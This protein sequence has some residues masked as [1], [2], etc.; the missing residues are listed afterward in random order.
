[1]DPDW[2]HFSMESRSRKG[3]FHE[4]HV[5]RRNGVIVCSCEDAVYRKKRGYV[6]DTDSPIVCYHVGRLLHEFKAVI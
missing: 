3:L 6:L 2:F 4:M 1:M 5:D